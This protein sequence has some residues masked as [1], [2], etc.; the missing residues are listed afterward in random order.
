[1]YTPIVSPK[2]AKLLAASYIETSYPFLLHSTAQAI[3]PIPAPTTITL[4]LGESFVIL[5]SQN[6]CRFGIA[7]ED[8]N[9]SAGCE[10]PTEFGTSGSWRS[11]Y[12]TLIRVRN[13]HVI[14][15]GWE[16]RGV[17]HECNAEGVRL[18]GLALA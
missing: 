14:W 13:R 8:P 2:R 5:D 15:E 9:L 18:F 3:P 11:C 17:D 6:V 10:L 1:M 12:S 4:K 7:W 16:V